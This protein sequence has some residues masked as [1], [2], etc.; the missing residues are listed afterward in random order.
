MVSRGYVTTPF[1]DKVIGFIVKIGTM[2][3]DQEILDQILEFREEFKSH[4]IDVVEVSN[5]ELHGY[6]R[7]LEKI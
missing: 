7:I 5:V 3:T 6:S 4:D 1:G 2:K